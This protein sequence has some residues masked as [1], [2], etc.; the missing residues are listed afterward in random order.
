MPGTALHKTN[1]LSWRNFIS[2]FEFYAK[3]K[4]KL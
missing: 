2:L 1:K 3:L 4:G